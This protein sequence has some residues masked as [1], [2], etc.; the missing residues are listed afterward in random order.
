MEKEEDLNKV[1]SGII[2]QY[3][4]YKSKEEI[5]EDLKKIFLFSE[6]FYLD[7][8]NNYITV[9]KIIED[10]NLEFTIGN[11]LLNIGRK[12]NNNQRGIS[13]KQ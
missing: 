3:S 6:K 9:D 8:I 13:W 4:K 11:D 12:Y 7:W 1:I 5:K 10:Y 2:K